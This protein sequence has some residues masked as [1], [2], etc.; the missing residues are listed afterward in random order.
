V[1]PEAAPSV[2]TAAEPVGGGADNAPARSK[3]A[4]AAPGGPGDTTAASADAIQPLTGRNLK[5]FSQLAKT[6]GNATLI[7][8]PSESTLWRVGKGGGIERSTDAGRSWIVQT[9]PSQ[10][11]W[12][13]GAAFSD[14]VCWLVGRN[15]AIA[16]TTDGGRW[17]KIA[18][19]RVAADSSGK[20]PDWT[21]L[22][23]ASAQAATI[24]ASDQRRYSTQ[25]GGKTWKAQ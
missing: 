14:T 10:E 20:L 2:S 18:P 21:S 9:S 15:G 23:V 1:V 12:L 24:T 8:T 11:E 4:L 7:R 19:P 13:A 17:K 22:T 5:S 3:Q 25:D 6:E 16:R